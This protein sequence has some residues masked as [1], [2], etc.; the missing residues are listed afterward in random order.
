MWMETTRG[1]SAVCSWHTDNMCDASLLFYMVS[2]KTSL[3][4]LNEHVMRVLKGTDS[5]TQWLH[6]MRN[7][8]PW[9]SMLNFHLYPAGWMPFQSH[10]GPSWSEPNPA[11]GFCQGHILTAISCLPEGCKTRNH[12]FWQNHNWHIGWFSMAGHNSV[13]NISLIHS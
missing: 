8:T 1:T 11:G 12:S 13:F 6:H 10:A 3:I 2:V 4:W 5:L 7:L 9:M